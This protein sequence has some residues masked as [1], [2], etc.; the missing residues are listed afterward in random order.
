MDNL[1]FSTLKQGHCCKYTTLYFFLSSLRLQNPLFSHHLL[2][3]TI[4]LNTDHRHPPHLR[5]TLTTI[6][7]FSLRSRSHVADDILFSITS[8]EI[9]SASVRDPSSFVLDLHRRRRQFRCDNEFS[10]DDE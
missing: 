5:Q 3:T 4:L 8:P 6:Y 9:R 2:T 10:D 1:D 7:L